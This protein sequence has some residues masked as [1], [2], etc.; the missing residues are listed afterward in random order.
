MASPARSPRSAHRAVAALVALTSAACGAPAG[1]GPDQ[2]PASLVFSA[3]KD[4][5]INLDGSTNVAST[6]VPGNAT[7]LASDLAASGGTA[8]TLAF[9]T[10]ECGDE[11]W[12]GVAGAALASANVPRLTG[13]GLRYIVST[14]GAAGSFT[15]GTDAGFEAFLARWASANLI[16]VDFDLEAGQPPAVIT[17]LVRRIAVAHVAHPGLRFS[18]TLAA[19][20][21]NLGA[22][23]ARSLGAGAPDSLNATGAQ[24]LAAVGSVLGF[25]GTAASWPAYLTV[26]LM[27]M[28]Y[29]TA[30][31]GLCV[32]SGGA[33]EMGESA[34]QAALN[35]HDRRG[36][37]LAAIELTAM[38][39]RNDVAGEQFTLANADTVASFA[40]ARG[41]AGVHYWS[42]DRDVD[43]VQPSASPTCNS[44]GG[45]GP[46]GFL[47]RFL[48]AGLP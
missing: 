41:L 43:C 14:G 8:I 46:H 33:C 17:E 19:L 38:I 31:P 12:G 30:G 10:G 6:R 2:P 21:G 9:A 42:Y 20:A 48:A 15:C 4:T 35:L 27:A 28:D 34:V 45:V 26:N 24:A 1:G 29:G 25:T 23:T 22:P 11:R 3:Y 5:S 32:V 44:V 47:R 40:I 36:V 39:G 16:G 13:A 7:E 37:P 18:L